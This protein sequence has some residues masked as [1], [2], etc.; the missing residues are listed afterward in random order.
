MT[1]RLFSIIKFAIYHF[2]VIKWDMNRDFEMV[3]YHFVS[4][5][6]SPSRFFFDIAGEFSR[7][8]R[9]TWII[10]YTILMVISLNANKRLTQLE[11]IFFSCCILVW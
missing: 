8:Y 3:Q 7:A 2:N 4:K 9:D 10:S 5:K 1:A 6:S 11:A